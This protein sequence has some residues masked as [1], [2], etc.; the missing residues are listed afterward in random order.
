M[1]H[2]QNHSRTRW[3][4]SRSRSEP[5]QALARSHRRRPW[6]CANL[7]DHRGTVSGSHTRTTGPDPRWCRCWTEL[8]S[9]PTRRADGTSRRF[10]SRRMD[11]IPSYQSHA[12]WYMPCGRSNPRSNPDETVVAW[13]ELRFPSSSG[14][15]TDGP[16]TR[17]RCYESVEQHWPLHGGHH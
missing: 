2:G 9:G 11:Q 16:G 4:T 5:Q 14:S 17:V 10:P 13:G 7:W 1:L 8:R 3:L 15:G 12:I 6:D